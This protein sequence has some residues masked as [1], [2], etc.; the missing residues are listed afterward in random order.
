MV[1]VKDKDGKVVKGLTAKDFT[2]TVQWTGGGSISLSTTV[3][4]PP[5]MSSG[6]LEQFPTVLVKSW[7]SQ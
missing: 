4:S 2:V 7:S 5:T 6:A 1:T 3:I